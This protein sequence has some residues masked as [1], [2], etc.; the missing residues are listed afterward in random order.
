M[1]FLRQSSDWNDLVPVYL[2]S[3]AWLMGANPYDPNIYANLW[4]QTFDRPWSPAAARSHAVYPITAFVL[5]SPLAALPWPAAQMVASA[6]TLLLVVIMAWCMIRF[7]ELEGDSRYLF[8][9][10]ALALAPFH[11]GLATGNISIAVVALAGIAAYAIKQDEY[12]WGG[13]LLAVAVGLKPQIGLCFLAYYLLRRRWRVCGVAISGLVVL[14][15]VAALRMHTLGFSWVTD[16]LRNNRAFVAANRF[17]DFTSA[18]PIRFTLIDLQVPL[19]D[20][21]GSKA[22]AALWA[23]GV[24]ILLAVVWLVLFLNT[25]KPDD[26]LNLSVI[27][28]LSLLPVYHRFYDAALLVFPLCWLLHANALKFFRL[29]VACA[30]LLVPFLFP[31]A[32]MLADAAAAGRIPQTILDSWAWRHLLMTHEIWALLLLVIVLLAAVR[33][34]MGQRLPS[35]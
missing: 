25:S 12:L 14:S 19:L 10:G 11:T 17:D 1:R 13:V 33:L 15:F 31:G 22:A 29:R 8:A 27:V 30:V 5:L 18:N 6:T 26:L 23:A 3:R 4:T 32:T 2:P 9:A 7:T 24:V 28:T 34:Q 21:T 20:F 16:F 35:R